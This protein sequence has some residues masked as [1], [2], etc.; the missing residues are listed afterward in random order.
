MDAIMAKLR[1]GRIGN[2][3]QGITAVA[4]YE[5][6]PTDARVTEFCKNL[7]RNLGSK[8]EITRQMWLLN[9]LRMPQLRAIAATEAASA[10]LIIISVHHSETLPHELKQWME[11]WPARKGKHSIVLL[12]L[13]D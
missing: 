12:A 10:D 1:T 11:S 7:S 9:E 4:A 5:D 8:C 2:G 3:S 6:A 13:F